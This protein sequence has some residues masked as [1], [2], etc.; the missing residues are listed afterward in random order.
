MIPVTDDPILSYLK[1]YVERFRGVPTI[2]EIEIAANF[3]VQGGLTRCLTALQRVAHAHL[4]HKP[5]L[6]ADRVIKALMDNH[7]IDDGEDP[8][9]ICATEA[10]MRATL[11]KVIS[12]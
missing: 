3:R 1:Q 5:T 9:V 8:P 12:K 4:H 7:K 10:E 2:R 6:D 11:A